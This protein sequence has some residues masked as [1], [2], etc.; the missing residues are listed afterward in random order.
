M[1]GLLPA[2]S[3]ELSDSFGSSCG[4]TADGHA[5]EDDTTPDNTNDTANTSDNETNTTNATANATRVLANATNTTTTA[6]GF[7]LKVILQKDLAAEDASKQIE[8]LT[9]YVGSDGFK[10][11]LNLVATT[12]TVSDAT[13]V[14]AVST[15]TE[16]KVAFSTS[17][18][19]SA[20]VLDQTITVQA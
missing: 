11:A 13:A 12:L 5:E 16:S 19:P 15:F 3:D 17:G 18:A 8:E 4:H 9:S 1:N 10:T 14:S 7:N 6:A 20:S 2:S